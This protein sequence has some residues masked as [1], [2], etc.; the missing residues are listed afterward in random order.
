M[1]L[2]HIQNGLHPTPAATIP[3]DFSCLYFHMALHIN[4]ATRISE[5]DPI[6]INTMQYAP[7]SWRRCK[8]VLRLVQCSDD[9]A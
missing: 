7:D 5:I 6:Y 9:L 4:T 8:T 2:G 3:E 1:R